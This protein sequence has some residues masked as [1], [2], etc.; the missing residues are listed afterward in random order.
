MANVLVVDDH[1]ATCELIADVLGDAG[2][3]AAAAYCAEEAQLLV[4]HERFDAALVD[5]VMPVES[6][7]ALAGRL[8]AAGVPVL[9]MTAHPEAAEMLP[10]GAPACL[11]KP[12]SVPALVT[13]LRA[14]I[15]RPLTGALVAL[16]GATQALI[17]PVLDL[18]V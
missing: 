15:G 13:A 6:G 2:F 4:R 5:L 12:F 9:L 3:R 16:L 8:L 14:A 17:G 7:A 1:P 18:L 11:V 10:A